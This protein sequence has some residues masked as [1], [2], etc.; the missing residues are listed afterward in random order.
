MFSSLSKGS[1]L[2]ILEKNSQPI[3]K[4]G[5]V[6]EVKVNPQFYGLSNQEIDLF[7][8]AAG[9]SYEFKKIPG[10]LSIISPSSGIII[11]DNAEDM[12]REYE[13]MVTNSRNILD[14]VEYHKAVIQ[15]QDE[16]LSILNPRYAK[17]REQENK[18]NSLE[19]RIKGMEKGIFDI[20]AI[21]TQIAEQNKEQ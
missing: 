9:E 15:S 16:I 21:L 17:E 12:T 7:V 10:N 13:S 19:D 3:L 5:K 20:Q 8:D 14:S 4:V 6:T 18:L 11:S 2:Y 1:D